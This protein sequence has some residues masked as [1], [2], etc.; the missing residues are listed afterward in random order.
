M[1]STLRTTFKKC[2]LKLGTIAEKLKIPKSCVTDRLNG[3]TEWRKS[4][5]DLILELTQEKYEDIFLKN[6][7]S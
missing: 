4:E 2:G 7:S 3:K 1:D 6:S 5:I